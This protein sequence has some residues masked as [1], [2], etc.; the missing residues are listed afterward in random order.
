MSCSVGFAAVTLE[1]DVDMVV[2]VLGHRAQVVLRLNGCKRASYSRVSQGVVKEAQAHLLYGF[3]KNSWGFL[4]CGYF[5]L[6][7]ALS[8]R[9]HC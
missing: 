6:F 9:F 3:G 2:D 1:A 4:V 8:E 7:D 5:K